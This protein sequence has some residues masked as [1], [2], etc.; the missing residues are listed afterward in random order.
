MIAPIPADGRAAVIPR[1][2][3][4]D[5]RPTFAALYEAEF[6]FVWRSARRLGAPQASI[7]DIVQ[8]IFVVV[9]RRLAEF[10]GRSLIRT[11]LFGIVV[12]VVRAHRRSLRAKHPHTLR[13][14]AGLDTEA[15]ADPAPGPQELVAAFEASRVVER[16]LEGLDDDKRAVFVLAE[17]E[18]MSA[19]DIALAVGVPLNTVY[20]RLRLARQEFAAAAARHR[21]KDEWRTR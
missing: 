3:V 6:A 10:E 9:Y 4:A 16:L 5:T 12:N 20:S 8:E 1:A 14:E 15:L 7:D 2:E 17:L 21:A 18:Q 11:W 13:T 19:P